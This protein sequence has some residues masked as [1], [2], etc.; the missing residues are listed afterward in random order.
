MAGCWS[1]AAVLTTEPRFSGVDQGPYSYR[2]GAL[3]LGGRTQPMGKR[4]ARKKRDD[5]AECFIE[6]APLDFGPTD[7]VRMDLGRGAGNRAG[8]SC[9]CLLGVPVSGCG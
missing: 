4:V 9:G 6:M 5:E 8:L 1:L 2:T 7:G 3:A